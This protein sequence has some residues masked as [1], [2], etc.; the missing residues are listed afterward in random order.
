MEEGK[1]EEANQ[2]REELWLRN[3][4]GCKSGKGFGRG[5]RMCG[6]MMGQGQHGFIDADGDGNCDFQQILE[7]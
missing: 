6:R 7:Q 3:G 2:I 5:N 1:I 4:R